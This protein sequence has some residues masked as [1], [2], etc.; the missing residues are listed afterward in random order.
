MKSVHAGWITLAFMASSATATA[1]EPKPREIAKFAL[2]NNMFATSNSRA[3]IK[4]EISKRGKV[5]RERTISTLMKRENELVRSFVEF[6]SPRNVAGTKFLSVEEEDGNT[7]QFI[8]L[9]AF[10]KVKRIVGTQRTQSFMGT[11]FSFSDLEGRDVDDTNWKR[12]AD[13]KVQGEDCWVIEGRPKKPEEEQYGRTVIW[14][15]KK[16]RIP[17]KS[18]FYDKKATKLLKQLEVKKLAKKDGRWIATDSVMKTLKKQTQTRL[19]VTS[20]DL[21]TIIDD[22]QF[23]REALER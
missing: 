18:D 17:L 22:S 14:I 16:N 13:E 19:L 4:M 15:H 3:T 7:Q 1:E 20:I 2:D 23:T 8:Y 21:K 12:L 11:D 10:K 6:Q 9:P 5:V